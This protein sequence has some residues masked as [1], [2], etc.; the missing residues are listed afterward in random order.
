MLFRSGKKILIVDFD[1]EAPGI[2]T[3]SL[4]APKVEV[5]GLVEY[6]TEFR[7]SGRSPDVRN[8]VYSAH[9]FESGGQLFVMPAGRHDGSY[10][11]RLNA[12]DWH[13]L[14]DEEDGYLF[15]EDL[16]R[17]WAINVGVDY[18]L[19]DS[20]TGHSDVEGICTRQLPDAVCLLF[21]PNEQNLQ[22]LKRVV[23]NVRAQNSGLKTQK[24]AISLH[25]AVSNVP[26]LDDEERIIGSTLDR[27]EK[28]LG[29]EELSG[30]IHHYNSLSLLN[31]EIFSEKRPNSRLAKEYKVLTDAIIKDN[32]SD[33][34]VATRFLRQ[35]VM[36]LRSVN[37]RAME[38]ASVERA[39]RVLHYFPSDTEIILDVALIYEGIGRSKDALTLLLSSNESQA[40]NYFATRARLNQRL[41]STSEAVADLQ[42]MLDCGDSQMPS[43]LEGL[44]IASELDSSLFHG[45]AHRPAVRSLS[46][47]ERRFVALQI[48]GGKSELEAQAEILEGLLPDSTEKDLDSN[49]IALASIGLGRFQRA[50]K[51]LSP[52]F[53]ARPDASISVAFNLGMA[54]WGNEGSPSAD[55]FRKVVELD[56]GATERDPNSNYLACVGIACAIIGRSED[57]SQ[58]F[59]RSSARMKSRPRREFSPWTYMKVSSKDFLRHLAKMEQQSIDGTVSPEFLNAAVIDNDIR[60]TPRDT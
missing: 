54:R 33:R 11:Q 30:Q 21:F 9:T 44:S 18:V 29:Y 23:G 38:T 31:Q 5:R 58:F 6:I 15:F 50:I 24:E 60:D 41:G 55:L 16:K 49:V 51:L 27:F 37:A 20:R 35:T 2:P 1:L 52:Y 12:I 57:A 46:P 39:E 17:Q 13:K 36:E 34:D 7:Q 10:S 8:F 32:I 25:F 19:I 59:S 22:G 42:R 53:E 14:Y 47:T 3:F 28:E 43:L 45:L 48:E 26:D 40:A 56:A 4:T